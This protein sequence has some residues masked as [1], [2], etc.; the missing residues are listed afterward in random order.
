MKEL[1]QRPEYAHINTVYVQVA[2]SES[3]NLSLDRYVCIMRVQFGWGAEKTESFI[4]RANQESVAP[5]VGHWLLTT[6]F[7][8]ENIRW[9]QMSPM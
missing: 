6:T 8:K 3:V 1:P 5:D 2:L 4:T 7:L 9:Y